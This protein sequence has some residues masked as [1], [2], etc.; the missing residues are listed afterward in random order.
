MDNFEFEMDFNASYFTLNSTLECND[1][2]YVVT[3]SP[4]RK[5]YLVLLQFISFG[6]YKA[7]WIYTIK[8]LN[9]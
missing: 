6:Y 8:P 2:L 4:Y 3:K 5:W 7:P 1:G 9:K